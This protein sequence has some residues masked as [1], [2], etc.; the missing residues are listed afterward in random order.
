[1]PTYHLLTFGCKSNQYESPAIRESL[2]R[3]G[4]VETANAAEADLLIVN[5]CG[6][7][8]RAGASCRNAIRRA[9]RVNPKAK[10]VITGCGVDLKEEW[11]SRLMPEETPLLV[12]NAKKHA[13]AEL[14][15]SP[16]GTNQPAAGENA[17]ADPAAF[18]EDRF[19][20]GISAF[21]GHTR[22]FLKIQDGCDNFC[23]YCAVPH[24][25]GRPESRPDRDILLEA[26]RLVAGGHRELVLTGIN[27]GAYAHRG[28]RLPELVDKLADTPGLERLRLGS[29]EPPHLDRPLVE[30]MR[31]RSGVICPH[32]HLPLQ[33]GDARVLA[34]MGRRYG[35]EEFLEKISLLR[36]NLERPAVTTDLIVGFPGEDENSAANTL[37]L[38]RR[39]AFSRLHVFLFS[40]RPGTP[41]ASLP[42]TAG[43][44]AVD[45]WKTRLIALGKELAAAYALS[46]VG[47]AERIIVE[48]DGGGFS[49][50]YVRVNLRGGVPG[51]VERV[52]ITGAAGEATVGEK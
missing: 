7:T 2:E 24:A 4:G 43:D 10:L 13:I 6:V 37:A 32:L 5:T 45:A 29:V 36:D 31:K 12:P 49:D 52:R 20:A 17:P 40:P 11:L 15:F 8:G 14:I 35:P 46:T 42:R 28:L 44:R 1:M 21:H 16:Y 19:A 22:A 9:R 34:L 23:S 18:P 48:R 50:R 41:A 38:C 3:R 33:S 26:A 39:A 25:R 51:A 27:I 30:V 47:T